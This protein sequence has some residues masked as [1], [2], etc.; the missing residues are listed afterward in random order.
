MEIYFRSIKEVLTDGIGHY[1]PY[2]SQQPDSVV[3]F[4]LYEKQARTGQKG[5]WK[6]PGRIGTQISRRQAVDSSSASLNDVLPIN[7]NKANLKLLQLLPGIGPTYARRII[8][9]RTNHGGFN[10]VEEL[11]QIKGI[12]RETMQ[13][14]RPDVVAH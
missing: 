12:G 7:I 6:H 11:I 5:I 2:Y 9:Y 8:K 3:A 4:K 1:V 14:L 13:I 10:S